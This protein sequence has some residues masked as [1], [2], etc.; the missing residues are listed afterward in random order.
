MGWR[1]TKVE[2]MTGFKMFGYGNDVCLLN[3]EEGIGCHLAGDDTRSFEGI[4]E[5]TKKE[6]KYIIQQTNVRYGY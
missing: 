5:W 1:D 6:F 4:I 3:D 2:E